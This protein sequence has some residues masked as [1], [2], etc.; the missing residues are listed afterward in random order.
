MKV[1]LDGHIVDASAP[2]IPPTDPAVLYGHG[3]FEVTRAYQGI[4]FRLDDHLERM[5]RSAHD[6]GLPA[7]PAASTLDQAIRHLCSL[8]ERPEAYV[9]IMLTAGGHHI[10]LTRPLDIPPPQ[11]YR[12]GAG[13]TIAPWR[14]DP[15]GPFHGHKTLNY[16]DHVLTRKHVRAAGFADALILA[17]DET[18]LEGCASNIFLARN[19]DLIT[20]SLTLHILPGV[21]RKVILEIAGR[22]R[23]HVHQRAVKKDELHEA[24][25]VF[26]TGSTLEILPIVRLEKSII[27]G[28]RP[29]PLTRLLSMAY[30][31]VVLTETHRASR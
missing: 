22:L 8:N 5:R 2:G 23:L 16:L 14:R 21:T 28:G 18:V 15:A 27:G 12:K 10:I 13:I 20:P 17:P 6:L 9:R 31:S 29:G 25:E 4:P 11:D 19:G 3:L 26:L 24:D 1:W 30:R 7:L